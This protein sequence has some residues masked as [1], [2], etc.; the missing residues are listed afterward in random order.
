MLVFDT[1]VDATRTSIRRGL[2]CFCF[3]LIWYYE[4]RISLLAGH[5]LGQRVNSREDLGPQLESLFPS[6]EFL[7]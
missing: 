6:G 2:R 5:R 7:T 3:R 4:Y 1:L